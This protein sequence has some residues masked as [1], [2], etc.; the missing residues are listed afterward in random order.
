MAFDEV[1]VMEIELT[2]RTVHVIESE[3]PLRTVHGK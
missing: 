2:L 3:W 1:P